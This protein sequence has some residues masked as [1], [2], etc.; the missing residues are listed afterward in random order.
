M[1]REAS[2]APEVWGAPE[3]HAR[4]MTDARERRG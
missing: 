4:R 3:V 2:A 1:S